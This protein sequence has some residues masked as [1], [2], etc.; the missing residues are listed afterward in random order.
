VLWLL[1]EPTNA[2]DS[3]A[4]AW[5]GTVLQAHRDRGGMVILASH[6]AVPLPGARQLTLPEGKLS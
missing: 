3:N 4:V 5:L 1:D 2:L 6:V